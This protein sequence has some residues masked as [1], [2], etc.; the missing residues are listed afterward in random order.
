MLNY[1]EC[2][3]NKT[4][5]TCNKCITNYHT[6]SQKVKQH[7][8]HYKLTD[9]GVV[10]HSL[11]HFIT[12]AVLFAQTDVFFYVHHGVLALHGLGFREGRQLRSTGVLQFEEDLALSV[13]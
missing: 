2:P 9:V 13:Q 8:N 1:R 3:P 6:R 7:T 5:H 11:N 12:A 10:D 4:M